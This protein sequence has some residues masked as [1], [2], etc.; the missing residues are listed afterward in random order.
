MVLC[1]EKLKVWSVKIHIWFTSTFF[2][3]SDLL[4]SAKSGCL[5]GY[6]LWSSSLFHQLGCS[7]LNWVIC[8]FDILVWI[9][10]SSRNLVSCECVLQLDYF[11]SVH[12]HSLYFIFVCIVAVSIYPWL[13]ASVCVML[14]LGWVWIVPNLTGANGLFSIVI[15]VHS[16]SSFIIWHCD[17]DHSYDKSFKIFTN[18]CVQL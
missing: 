11:Y 6:L 17:I 16:S 5:C 14:L 4:S 3:A 1:C 7:S 2:F 15:L 10:Y 18:K 12:C 13:V 9:S 8:T